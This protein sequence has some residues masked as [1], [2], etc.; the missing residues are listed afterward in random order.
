MD[1]VKLIINSKNY[2]REVEFPTVIAC[3]NW[4]RDERWPHL[5]NVTVSA[6]FKRHPERTVY[7]PRHGVY[8]IEKLDKWN[9][10]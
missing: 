3:V 5:S 8:S 7:A 1:R 10:K 6:Y 9:N 4:L 2:G